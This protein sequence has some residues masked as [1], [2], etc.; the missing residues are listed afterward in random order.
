MLGLENGLNCPHRAAASL[1][2][3]TCVAM[4]LEVGLIRSMEWQELYSS[5][6]P[7]SHAQEREHWSCEGVESLVFF[8]TWEALKDRRE[9]DATLIVRGRMR[10][11]TE[12]GMKVANNLLHVSSYQASNIIQTEHWNVVGWITRK[13]LPFCFHPILITSCLR[14]KDT[15]LSTWY[16]F[17][18]QESVGTRLLSRYISSK[19]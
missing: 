15:R 18:F 12:K 19:E 7:G 14:R 17:M 6:F 9:V 3:E 5:S 10:L 16:I 4:P 13:T 1:K 11:R 2:F 8:L